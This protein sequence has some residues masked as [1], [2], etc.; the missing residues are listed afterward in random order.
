MHEGAELAHWS[1]QRGARAYSIVIAHL[2]GVSGWRLVGQVQGP[3]QQ[4]WLIICGPENGAEERELSQ[5]RPL[6]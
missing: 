5:P 3:A 4:H 6:R 2:E 1:G